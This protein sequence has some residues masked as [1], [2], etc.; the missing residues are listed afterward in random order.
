[1]LDQAKLE[2][3]KTR[4]AEE[5]ESIISFLCEICAIPSVENHIRECGQ[6]I[7]A[8]MK[9]LDYDEIWWDKMGNIVGKNRRWR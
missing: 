7:A 6:R 8:E 1:M 4:V 5:R 2:K 3:L 9:R